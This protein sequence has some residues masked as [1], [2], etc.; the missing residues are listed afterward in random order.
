MTKQTGIGL[1][2]LSVD[3]VGGTPRDIRPQV[4]NWDLAMPR[5]VQDATG[6]DATAMDRL[7]LLADSS[8]NLTGVVDSAS[9]QQ[10]DV[11]KTVPTTSVART[12]TIDAGTPLLANEYLFTDY[13]WTRAQDGSLVWAAP[14]VLTGGTFSAW[15]T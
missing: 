3:D 4:T 6:Q 9:N 10:H 14:G 1:A 5:G 15:T 8:V 7:L 2:A 13:T 11:F 12:V